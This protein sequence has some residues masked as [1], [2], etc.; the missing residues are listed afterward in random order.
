MILGFWARQPVLP[1]PGTVS[2]SQYS[3]NQNAAVWYDNREQQPSAADPDS[4]PVN[5]FLLGPV[6]LNNP[7][8]VGTVV[9]QYP[10]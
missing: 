3:N 4:T 6:Y 8:G 7:S 5:P 1:S 2:Q 9:F 10:P